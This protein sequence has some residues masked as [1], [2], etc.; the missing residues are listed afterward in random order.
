MNIYKRDVLAIYGTQQ[1]AADALGIKRGAVAM[2]SNERPIPER[3]A[4]KLRYE[5]RP[6]LFGAPV[7]APTER[8]A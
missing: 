8:T 2:W 6:D 7:T 1:A 3:H 5:L 4:L